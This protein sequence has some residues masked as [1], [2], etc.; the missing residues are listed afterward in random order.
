MKPRKQGFYQI[1]VGLCFFALGAFGFYWVH[2]SSSFALQDIEIDLPANPYISKKQV[3]ILSG[4]PLGQNLFRLDLRRIERQLEAHPWV[5]R[6]FVSRRLPDG[7]YIKITLEKPVAMVATPKGVYLVNQQGRLF[8]PALPLQMKDYPALAGVSSQE[9][10]A[11]SL[12]QRYRPLLKLLAYLRK[13]DQY[14]PCYA[15]ISQ[16]KLLKEGFVLLTRDAILVHFQGLDFATLWRQY[17]YLDR[18][19]AYLYDTKQ[20]SRAKVIRFDYPKGRA[21]I[22]F[23]EG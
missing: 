6:A 14:L 12:D 23:K 18:I 16:I 11:R 1:L 21:A 8:A 5:A 10:A 19:M 9:I 7:L 15:N 20:Y 4:A 13:H 22:S 3:L 17:R 2:H